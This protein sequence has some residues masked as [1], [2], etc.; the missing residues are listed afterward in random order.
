MVVTSSLKLFTRQLGAGRLMDLKKLMSTNPVR[1]DNCDCLLI[2]I[3][4]VESRITGTRRE[5]LLR[6]RLRFRRDSRVKDFLECNH[7]QHDG[8]DCENGFGVQV[9]FHGRK[10]SI[11]RACAIGVVLADGS[12]IPLPGYATSPGK[13]FR[14]T[15]S[16]HHRKRRAAKVVQMVITSSPRS[17]RSRCPPEA[18]N[19]DENGGNFRVADNPEVNGKMGS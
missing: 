18:L 1:I 7:R 11:V 2:G 13:G 3:I 5:Q 15:R 10:A 6:S 19:R 4:E 9:W 16:N 14:D 12:T 8:D 17:P